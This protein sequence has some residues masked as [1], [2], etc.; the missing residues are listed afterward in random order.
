MR[1]LA[2]LSVDSKT[3]RFRRPQRFAAQRPD[4]LRVETLGL[5]NQIAAV[6][7]TRDQRYELFESSQN[8]LQKGA[9]TRELLW[10]VARIDLAPAEVVELL[11]GTP[12][13]FAALRPGAASRFPDGGTRVPLRDASGRTRL[14]LDFDALGRLRRCLRL[15]PSG[16]ALWEARLDD[17]RDLGGTSFAFE[18]RLDFPAQESS[19]VFRFRDVELNPELPPELFVLKL[20]RAHSSSR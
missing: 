16:G 6:L 12:P 13:R 14:R 20:P 2:R 7:V 10:R 11:L 19:A 8:S 18:V 3:L 5:F 4:R 9:V 15:S 17:Y 1:G